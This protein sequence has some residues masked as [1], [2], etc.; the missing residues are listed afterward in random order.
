MTIGS[1]DG[2]MLF[3]DGEK[4]IDNW[5]QHSYVSKSKVLTLGEGEHTLRMEYYNLPGI[6]WDDSRASFSCDRDVLTY[7]EVRTEY[8]SLLQLLTSS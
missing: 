5:G 8:V 2:S 3:V 4:V 6:L 7:R 1:D